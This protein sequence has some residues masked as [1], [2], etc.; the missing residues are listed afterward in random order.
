M[1]VIAQ[2]EIELREKVDKGIALPLMEDFYTIQGEGAFSGQAAYFVRLAGCDVGCVWCDV[3]ESWDADQHPVIDIS[4]ICRRVAASGSRIVVITGGEPLMYNLEPLTAKLKTLGVRIHIETSAA[5]PL[6]GQ[7]DWICFSPKKF[8][9][10]LEEVYNLAHELKV[11]VFNASDLKWAETHAAKIN[12]DCKLLLQP[13]WSKEKGML[14][15]I[16]DYVKEN[17]K[18]QI[19]LQTHKYMDI[20]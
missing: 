20:P 7:L 4:E 5:H 10:P 2:Q 9:A 17:P 6:S 13:E 15:L 11:V 1:S 14:P 19:S 8:K 18:W 16:I 3:K 12:P